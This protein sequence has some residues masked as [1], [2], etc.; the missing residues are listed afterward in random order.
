MK[1][2]AF[3]NVSE[4]Y[5]GQAQ[6]IEEVI[7]NSRSLYSPAAARNTVSVASIAEGGQEMEIPW[8]P[9]PTQEIQ[10]N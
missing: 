3:N 8:Y 10:L 9:P 1:K 5:A 6:K 7:S 2:R 4:A